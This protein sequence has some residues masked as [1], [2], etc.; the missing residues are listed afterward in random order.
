MLAA[1]QSSQDSRSK[2]CYMNVDLNEG[3]PLSPSLSN[4]D[5]VAR[6]DQLDEATKHEYMNIHP[7]QEHVDASLLKSRPPPLP[8]SPMD[9]EEGP[10]HCYANLEANEIESFRKRFSGVFVA[11]KTAPPSTPP[12]NVIRE[13][14]YAVLDLDTKE[15]A[16]LTTN[17]QPSPPDSP[18]RSQKSYATIDFN[19]T[20]ALSHSVN[21]NLVNDNEGSRKTRHNSTINDFSDTKN[22]TTE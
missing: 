5:S 2:A 11:E 19:K 8:P 21:P 14:N 10:R 18:N 7:G 4:L 17:T 20:V 9:P 16:D 6:D 15:N 13:V 3:G 22:P 1:D 12:S